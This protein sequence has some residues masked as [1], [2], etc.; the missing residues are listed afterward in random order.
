MEGDADKLMSRWLVVKRQQHLPEDATAPPSDILEKGF[1]AILTWVKQ[2]K[3]HRSQPRNLLEEELRD[4]IVAPQKL[5]KVTEHL[6][7]SDRVA[8]ADR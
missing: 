4:S 6:F 5:N 1:S 3:A 7:I 2:E 8:A